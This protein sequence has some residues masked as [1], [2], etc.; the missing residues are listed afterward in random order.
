[1][2]RAQYF[3]TSIPYLAIAATGTSQGG[4]Y[5]SL[6]GS[7]SDSNT[8]GCSGNAFASAFMHYVSVS[9]SGLCGSSYGA[10]ANFYDNYNY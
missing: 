1:M 6:S 3:P 5:G 7:A 4:G 2:A 9:V 8:N 10:L